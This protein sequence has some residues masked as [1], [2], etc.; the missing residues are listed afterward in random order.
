MTAS[1]CL[2]ERFGVNQ[3]LIG[4]LAERAADRRALWLWRQAAGAIAM[5]LARDARAHPI[6][7]VRAVV[8]GFLLF[9][10][11]RVPFYWVWR[12]LDPVFFAALRLMGVQHLGVLTSGF[13]KTIT[14]IPLSFSI[15]WLVVRLNR[16][17]TPVAIIAFL[18]LSCYLAAPEFWRLAM[19]SV[20]Q[21]R[22]RPYLAL[23]VFRFAAFT[24]SVAA[25]ALRFQTH[26]ERG[27]AG[28]R[29]LDPS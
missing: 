5:A 23:N 29:R 9:E 17:H 16:T 18:T 24:L 7:V 26:T 22:F 28:T 19:N 1:I 25:G 20:G 2:M 21:G 14:A 27:L 8:L 10:A 15:G 12:L 13:V 6:I 3:A 11:S 4:D